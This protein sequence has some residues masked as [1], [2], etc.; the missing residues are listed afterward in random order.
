MGN[1]RGRW[2]H[3]GEASTGRSRWFGV[4]SQP[5]KSVVDQVGRTID[6][7]AGGTGDG[8]SGAGIDCSE[9]DILPSV[10][11]GAGLGGTAGCACL[12]WS[13][14]S[15]VRPH[16]RTCTRYIVELRSGSQHRPQSGTS[17]QCRTHP[18]LAAEYHGSRYSCAV[19]CHSCGLSHYCVLAAIMAGCSGGNPG[20]YNISYGQNTG[21]LAC[22]EDTDDMGWASGVDCVVRLSCIG[23]ATPGDT[24]LCAGQF[25]TNS[26]TGCGPKHIWGLCERKAQHQAVSRPS[27]GRERRM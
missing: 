4:D 12:G 5:S 3:A 27:N 16:R 9:H 24:G 18:R 25:R 20:H 8:H 22:T 26:I 21:H 23:Q 7:P 2:Q 17:G 19:L 15:N 1:H 13:R 11:A 6:R 14:S 10:A